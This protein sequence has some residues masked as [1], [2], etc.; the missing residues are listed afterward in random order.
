MCPSRDENTG[1]QRRHGPQNKHTAP[2]QDETGNKRTAE[3]RPCVVSRVVVPEEEQSRQR[4]Q[5]CLPLPTAPTRTEH[6]TVLCQTGDNHPGRCPTRELSMLGWLELTGVYPST[7]PV[8]AEHL[9]LAWWTSEIVSLAS[10]LCAHQTASGSGE[11]TSQFPRQ[12][13]NP[14]TRHGAPSATLPLQLHYCAV[15]PTICACI[16]R[17]FVNRLAFPPEAV[18]KYTFHFS[19]ITL[20]N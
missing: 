1:A 6:T 13:Y 5:S 4:T 3:K 7:V 8:P 18:L 19:K 14:D 12:R 2:G 16:Q 9:Q 11:W 10:V 15:L 17:N 20:C